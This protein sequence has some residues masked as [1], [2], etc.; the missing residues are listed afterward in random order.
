MTPGPRAYFHPMTG[1]SIA[2]FL[3]LALLG[4]VIAFYFFVQ[5]RA[6]MGKSLQMMAIWALIF[7]GAVAVYGLWEDIGGE[8]VPRQ[9]VAMDGSVTVP[10]GFDGHYRMTLD[11]QDVPVE[12]IVDTG[13]TDLVL[14]RADAERAGIDT[15]ALAWTGRARTANGTVETASVVLDEVALGD[16]VDR[17]VRAAVNGGEMDMSLLGM[18]YLE[19]FGRIEISGGELTLER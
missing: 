19:R 17:N 11:V 1:D 9:D 4:S 2:S 12:F 3:Y 5:N 14:S 16:A 6:N 15:D 8:L 18:T 7:V 13:A 10:R